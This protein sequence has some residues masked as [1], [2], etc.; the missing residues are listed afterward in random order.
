M[1]LFV[2]IG[3]VRVVNE[4]F[5]NFFFN[6]GFEFLVSLNQKLKNPNVCVL[7]L[8]YY[9][10]KSNPNTKIIEFKLSSVFDAKIIK[11]WNIEPLLSHWKVTSKKELEYVYD[12]NEM[13]HTV[14]DDGFIQFRVNIVKLTST[15]DLK[16]IKSCKCNDLESLYTHEN[17][18]K[19]PTKAK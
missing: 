2:S 17:Q 6:A 18:Y 12:S 11:D 7:N 10:R 1:S 16:L 4:P 3:G 9:E 15:D 14:N 19:I 5:F 13:V 8:K